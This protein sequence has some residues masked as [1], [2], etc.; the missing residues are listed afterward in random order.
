[1]M[2]KRVAS[3]RDKNT[4]ASDGAKENRILR[5][6]ATEFAKR[7]FSNATMDDIAR[8][9]G[10]A[11]GTLY[12]YFTSKHNLFTEMVLYMMS[13]VR[14]IIAQQVESLTE[15][16]DKLDRAMEIMF[17]V[18]QEYKETA[19]LT[20]PPTFLSKDEVLRMKRAG[21]GLVDLFESML[22]ECQR[23]VSPRRRLNTLVLAMTL[24]GGIA[25]YAHSWVQLKESLPSP[26]EYLTTYKTVIRAA[27]GGLH[28]PPG[29]AKEKPNA[30]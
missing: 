25:G 3:K 22:L 17:T 5:A 8:R 27:L 9:A 30:K 29:R 16:S 11:K 7:G 12:L 20:E 10:V 26:E 1:M 14:E 15:P 13:R 21:F 18:L 23:A 4:P 2:F 24:V 28:R 6:A 19:L